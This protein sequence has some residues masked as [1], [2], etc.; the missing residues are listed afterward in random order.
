[1]QNQ[2]DKNIKFIKNSNTPRTFFILFVSS[3]YNLRTIIPLALRLICK[4]QAKH[5]RLDIVMT[6]DMPYGREIAAFKIMIDLEYSDTVEIILAMAN[7][8]ALS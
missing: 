4:M 7:N 5:A 1:M 8:A 6:E 2:C 3:L